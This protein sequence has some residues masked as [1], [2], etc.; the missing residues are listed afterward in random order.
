MPNYRNG[1][2]SLKSRQADKERR[3]RAIRRQV[4]RGEILPRS[5]EGP[6]RKEYK[7]RGVRWSS[8]W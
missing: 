4:K 8:K 7:V 6:Q 2:Y 3:E 1:W 5:P